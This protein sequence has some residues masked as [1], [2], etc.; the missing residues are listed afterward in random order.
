[1]KMKKLTAM[2]LVLALGFAMTACGAKEEE[3]AAVETTETAE[4]AETETTGVTDEEITITY[5]TSQASDM[6][7]KVF[8][9]YSKLHPNVHLDVQVVDNSQLDTK[10]T[11]QV[12]TNTLPDLSWMNGA[13]WRDSFRQSES[14]LD[15]T[16]IIKNEIGED[17]FVTDTFKQ[18]EADG[19][20]VAFPA[21]SQIQGFL[22]NPGLFEKCG[23]EIPKT[24]AELL[25]CAKVFKENGITLFGSGTMDQWPTWTWYQWLRLWGIEELTQDIFVDHSLKWDESDVIQMYYALAELNEAGAFPENNS[26]VTYEQSKIM[27]LAEECAVL[28]TSTDQLATIV[29]SDLDMAGNIQYW[30]GTE[31]EESPYPQNRVVKVVNNGFAVS[32]SIT[33]DKLAVIVDFFKYFYSEE[34]ANILIQDGIVLPINAD[35]TAEISPLTESIIELT[36]DPSY[37]ATLGAS[38]TW[39]GV[40]DMQ[41]EYFLDF[42]FGHEELMNGLIDGS[43]TA[44]D[45]P[46]KAA[47][48]DEKIVSGIEMYNAAKAE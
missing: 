23:L 13:F 15:L 29:N 22:I 35:V 7:T 27:F 43:L 30:F 26:T 40:H 9:E 38:Y 20:I 47:A 46:A 21:E 5:Q 42:Y 14:V 3:P 25:N 6:V 11:A 17:A 33:E 2:L 41:T 45:I 10:V 39:F 31:F 8:E 16:D 36:Q 44:D 32:S 37:E 24:Y 48:M 1:M 34:A 19:S 12:S 18:L 28:P 4:T